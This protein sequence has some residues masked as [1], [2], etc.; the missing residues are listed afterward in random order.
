[1]TGIKTNIAP[2]LI[3]KSGRSSILNIALI[4]TYIPV[5]HRRKKETLNA[6]VNLLE[7]PRNMSFVQSLCIPFII[8]P[9]VRVVRIITAPK[10]SGNT[11]MNRGRMNIEKFSSTSPLQNGTARR[12]RAASIADAIF[13]FFANWGFG[14][15]EMIGFIAQRFSAPN[16][17]DSA[18]FYYFYHVPPACQPV[19][20]QR[21]RIWVARLVRHFFDSA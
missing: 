15:H 17:T 19:T 21:G 4:I 20:H 1:M 6:L 14:I 7:S 12:H 8:F 16:P 13:S 2:S 11:I 10:N 3:P 9:S 18:R 5:A